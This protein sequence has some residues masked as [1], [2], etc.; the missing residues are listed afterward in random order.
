MKYKTTYFM[1][2]I[3]CFQDY[4]NINRIRIC[5]D[6]HIKKNNKFL[7]IFLFTFL[8]FCLLEQSDLLYIPVIYLGQV[9]C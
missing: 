3:S 9:W 4:V 6:Y 5:N 7:I 1:V 2:Q 8:L